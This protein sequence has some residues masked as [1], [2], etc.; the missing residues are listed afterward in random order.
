MTPKEKAQELFDNYFSE[1][2][3][4]SDCEGCMQCVDRCGNMV[5]IAKKYALIAVDEII[6]TYTN[7]DKTYWLLE[8]EV[9]YWQQVKSEIEAL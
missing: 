5:A 3:M 2:R 4:P 7:K 8:E 1:I 9:D 6:K